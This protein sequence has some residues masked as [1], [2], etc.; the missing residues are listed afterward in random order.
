M[1]TTP[2]HIRLL[3]NTVKILTVN[4]TLILHSI[5]WSSTLCWL[6]HHSFSHAAA[7]S[8]KSLAC[9]M[10]PMPKISDRRV[11]ARF[12]LVDHYRQLCNNY[13]TEVKMISNLK[14]CSAE[15]KSLSKCQNSQRHFTYLLSFLLRRDIDRHMKSMGQAGISWHQQG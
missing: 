11:D 12:C 3:C 7:N 5:N 13:N 14:V 1:N 10:P 6:H 15:N 4:F 2:T 9:Q 8:P